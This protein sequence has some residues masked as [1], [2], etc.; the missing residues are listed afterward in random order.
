MPAGATSKGAAQGQCGRPRGYVRWRRVILRSVISFLLGGLGD[1]SP[2]KRGRR[3]VN[4]LMHRVN[5]ESAVLIS[6]G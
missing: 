6:A 3:R 2:P 4:L 5:C 1:G